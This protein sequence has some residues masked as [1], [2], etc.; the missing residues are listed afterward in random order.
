MFKW[1]KLIKDINSAYSSWDER[2]TFTI[3]GIKNLSISDLETIELYA[4]TRGEGL[5]KPVGSVATVL[6]K[7][8]FEYRR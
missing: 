4:Q 6:G 1:E 3:V 5:M 2:S 7:Y 8:G